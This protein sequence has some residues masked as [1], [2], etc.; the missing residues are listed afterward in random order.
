MLETSDFYLLFVMAFFVLLL[1]IIL[2]VYILYFFYLNIYK[3][4]K[5]HVNLNGIILNP[6]VNL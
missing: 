2:A 4:K 1:Q 6:S 5:S 3:R